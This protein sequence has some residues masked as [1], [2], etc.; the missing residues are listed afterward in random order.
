MHLVLLFL[1]I[2]AINTA[3]ATEDSAL[4]VGL[5]FAVAGVEDPAGSTGNDQVFVPGL[6]Y[7]GAWARDLDY[8]VGARYASGELTPTPTE[9]G[10]AFSH[11]ELSLALHKRLRLL[12]EF[13][14]WVGG[15]VALARDTFETRQ[16][17]DGDGFLKDRYDNRESTGAN[18]LLEVTAQYRTQNNHDWA[19]QLQHQEPLGD[20]VRYSG[21]NLM[22][23]F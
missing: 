22:W 16:T 20:R 9:I 14:T 11:L 8:A 3:A 13:K 19:V 4:G 23:L 10:Q 2:F 12:R 17:V 1:F 21:V 15:G 5:G 18:V 7:R 6:F